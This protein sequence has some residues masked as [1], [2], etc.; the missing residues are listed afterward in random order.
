MKEALLDLLICPACL[1]REEALAC[2]AI[3]RKGEEIISGRLLCE[4][5]K[6]EYP[7]REGM[8]CLLPGNVSG[9]EPPSGYEDPSVVSSYLWT[10]YSDLTGD[11]EAGPAYREWAELMAPHTGLSLDAGCAVGRFSFEMSAKSGLVVGIDNS[12]RFIQTARMLLHERHMDFRIADEGR[13]QEEVTID[14]PESWIS[15]RAEFV[16]GDVQALPFRSGVFSSLASLN[17]VDKVP[18]PLLHLQE[19]NRVAKDSGAQALLSDPFSW[20]SR[21]ASETDWLGGTVT[22]HNAGRGMEN[23]RALLTEGGKGLLP[24]WQ[25]ERLGHVWWKI[26]EHKNLYQLIRSLYVKV[27]R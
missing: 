19:M 6:K 27:R 18:L 2:R 17:I 11:P 15:D 4:H 12:Y 9:S 14:L 23:M 3:D 8:A 13:M 25:E 7:I 26:R 20:S 16:Q 10:H 22:G 21:V 1:P 5:C 24:P